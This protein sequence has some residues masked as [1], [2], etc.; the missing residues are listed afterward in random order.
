MA[1]KIVKSLL[2]IDGKVKGIQKFGSSRLLFPFFG[3]VQWV[4][5]AV[6]GKYDVISFQGFEFD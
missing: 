3:I 2:Y 4:P 1:A 6:G 5:S